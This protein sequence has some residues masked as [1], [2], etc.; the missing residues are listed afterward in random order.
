MIDTHD[1]TYAAVSAA[2][3]SAFTTIY[4][5][6]EWKNTIA[7]FPCMVMPEIDNSETARDLSNNENAANIGMQIDVYSNAE[8]GNLN[9]RQSIMSTV[10]TTM[11]SLGYHRTYYN[12]DMPNI[13]DTIKRTC[14]RYAILAT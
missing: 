11:H 6:Q 1:A 13:D 5:Y 14:A 9:E 3:R 10:D 4:C 7:T 2:L 12:T 8:T